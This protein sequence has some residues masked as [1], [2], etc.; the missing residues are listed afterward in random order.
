M[1]VD[2]YSIASV[3]KFIEKSL[4][5][6]EKPC[7]VA[8][9][10]PFSK[11]AE[12]L[13][14]SADL[15]REP[16]TIISG[17]IKGSLITVN[18]VPML[19]SNVYVASTPTSVYLNAFLV[20]AHQA[21]SGSVVV[22]DELLPAT[23]DT[24]YASLTAFYIISLFLIASTG[25]M[26]KP[27]DIPVLKTLLLNFY[28]Q[29]SQADE[30]STPEENAQRAIDSLCHVYYPNGAYLS[31]ANDIVYSADCF[32][33]VCGSL[34]DICPIRR[35]DCKC[36]CEPKCPDNKRPRRECGLYDVKYQKYHVFDAEC[37]VSPGFYRS[38][39]CKQAIASRFSANDPSSVDFFISGKHCHK[40]EEEKS[41]HDKDRKDH[42][43]HKNKCDPCEK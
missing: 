25:G 33:V 24:T 35:D 4:K 22:I 39:K 40:K 29:P 31:E 10:L 26:F 32:Q 28:S 42:H 36:T 37:L 43:D 34:I 14:K 9:L 3:Q 2:T 7:S 27:A 21:L 20:A 16:F 30:C 13:L 11:Y 17:M 19:D 1:S 41:C 6:F 38:Y 15:L 18:G 23:P 5:H 12:E 8:S